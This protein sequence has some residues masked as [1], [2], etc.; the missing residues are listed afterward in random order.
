MRS[1]LLFGTQRR[2]GPE[3][4][5]SSLR[6][7]QLHSRRVCCCPYVLWPSTKELQAS[8]K[9]QGP[10]QVHCFLLFETIYYQPKVHLPKNQAANAHPQSHLAILQHKRTQM[11]LSVCQ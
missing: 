11:S 4:L 3:G 7:T 5:T 1:N 6:I 9:Q 2:P 10:S 8:H